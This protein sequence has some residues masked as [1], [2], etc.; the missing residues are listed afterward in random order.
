MFIS[1]QEPAFNQ[2]PYYKQA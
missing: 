1:K 2:T